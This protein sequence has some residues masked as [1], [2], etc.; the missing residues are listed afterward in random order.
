MG[1]FS[2]IYFT[3]LLAVNAPPHRKKISRDEDFNGE[4]EKLNCVKNLV[5]N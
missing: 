5:T 4:R 2:V 1:F 3:T